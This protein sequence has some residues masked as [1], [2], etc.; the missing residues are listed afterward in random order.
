M[1]WSNFFHIYQPPAW[2]VDIVRQVTKEA[3]RPI[4]DILERHPDLHITLNISGSLIEQLVALELQDVLENFS[5]LAERGQVEIVGSAM[6]HPILPL[7]PSEE[8]KRQIQL[9]ESLLR[10]YFGKSFSPKGFFVPEMAYS[11]MLEPILSE[12]GYQW[13][14]LDEPSFEKNGGPVLFDTRYKTKDGLGLIFRNRAISDYLSFTAEISKPE[15]CLRAITE[16]ERSK[17]E[18]ITA[19]D[20]EN[21]GHHR[22]GV[23]KLWEFLVTW[24]GI[25]TSTLSQYQGS[26]KNE[27]IIVPQAASWSSQP[28]EVAA[29]IPFGLWDHRDNPIHKLQWELTYRV[30]E[31]VESSQ[32][33]AHYEAA[34]KLLDRALASDKYWW[35]SASPWWDVSIVIRETQKL[36]DVVTPLDSLKPKTRNTIERLMEQVATTAELWEKTGLAKKRQATYLESSGQTHY[37]G[38]SKVTK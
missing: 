26:L 37:M 22:H 35:A 32:S 34:R 38:G 21:L 16:D 1:R 30:I 2:N 7:L 23:E 28:S 33:D 25:S 11:P 6:Y 19:M 36:A 3:Y 27:K 17:D 4:I 13:V 18:L 29:D 8:I 20:G 31:T 14:I 5:R 12:F 10:K 24:P 15:D 9:Q